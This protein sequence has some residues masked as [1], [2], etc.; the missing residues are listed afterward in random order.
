MV[1]RVGGVRRRVQHGLQRVRAPRVEPQ[2]VVPLINDQFDENKSQLIRIKYSY[3]LD[4]VVVGGQRVV[5][6][7]GRAG[8]GGHHEALL[9]LLVCDDDDESFSQF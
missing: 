8:V 4:V 6:G 1:E 3:L 9:S 7:P 2:E 5:L